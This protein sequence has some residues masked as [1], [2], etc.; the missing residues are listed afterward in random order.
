VYATYAHGTGRV[1]VT[2]VTL[3]GPAAFPTLTAPVPT[4]TNSYYWI[5]RGAGAPTSS[6]AAPPDGIVAGSAAVPEDA[7]WVSSTRRR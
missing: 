4:L 3:E 6:A 5:L 2:T 7:S 1:I